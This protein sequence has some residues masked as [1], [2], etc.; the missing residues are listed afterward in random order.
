MGGVFTDKIIVQR[1]T[2]FRWMAISSTEEDTLIYDNARVLVAV[3]NCI[4]ELK[5]YYHGTK[6]ATIPAF[7]C[8]QPHPRYF[9]Y[10]TKFRKEGTEFHFAYRKSLENHPSSVTYLA[11]ITEETTDK[12]DAGVKV[13]VKFV[14]SYG[15]EVHEFLA[16][17]GWAPKLRYCSP[18]G[19]TRPPNDSTEL[20]QSAPPGLHSDVMQMVVMDYVEARHKPPYDAHLQVK[21]VLTRLHNEGYVY[22]DLRGP[23]ILFDAND[24]VKFVDFDWCG[25]Y[26]RGQTDGTYARYP[27]RISNVPDMWPADAKPLTQ[28]RPAHDLEMLKKL[29]W[30]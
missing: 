8:G 13:V 29:K 26:D 11:E 21:K 4:K 25:R 2:G 24:Q 9:P 16:R 5:K 14:T 1:L 12:T 27:L 15:K 28:I 23:N 6:S 3:R 19:K 18:L 17:E 10:P 7:V 20:L 30:E 22:G